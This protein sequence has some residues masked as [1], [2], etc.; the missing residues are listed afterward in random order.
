LKLPICS[1]PLAIKTSSFEA[2]S[3]NTINEVIS[4]FQC[5][6]PKMVLICP[7]GLLTYVPLVIEEDLSHCGGA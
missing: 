5:S 3:S 6:N 4:M 7:R 2:S 1:R